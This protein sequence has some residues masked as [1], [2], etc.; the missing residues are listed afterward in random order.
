MALSVQR[1]RVRGIHRKYR[2]GA[3]LHAYML[4]CGLVLAVFVVRQK[5]DKMGFYSLLQSQVV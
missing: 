1:Y 2:Q 4:A 3:R 5:N